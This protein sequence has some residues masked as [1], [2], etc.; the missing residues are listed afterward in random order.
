MGSSRLP[1]KPLKKILGLTMLEHVYEDLLA[2]SVDDVFVATCDEEIK[3][4]VER[5]GGKVL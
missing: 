3:N 1:G 2:K 4:E 5:F